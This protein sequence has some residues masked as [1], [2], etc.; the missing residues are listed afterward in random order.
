MG[1]EKLN[2][3]NLIS[4][5]NNQRLFWL[6]WQKNFKKKLKI[7]EKQSF[8]FNSWHGFTTFKAYKTTIGPNLNLVIYK[9]NSKDEIVY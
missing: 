1:K 5:F 9:T 6:K 3:S 4:T 2:S 7:F 8:S